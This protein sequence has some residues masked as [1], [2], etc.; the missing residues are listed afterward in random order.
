MKE[1]YTGELVNNLPDGYGV[2][3]G[4]KF[5]FEGEEYDYIYIGEFKQ[6]KKH[7]TGILKLLSEWMAIEELVTAQEL[8]REPRLSAIHEFIGIFEED[9]F[10]GEGLLL[11]DYK[12]HVYYFE[13]GI[14]RN[15]L[16]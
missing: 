3:Y 8:N 15:K 13:N 6:G 7:G 12:N 9:E 11:T 14:K 2:L 16:K 1:N 4:T 5:E 10:T